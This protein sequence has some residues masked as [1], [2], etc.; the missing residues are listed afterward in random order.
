MLPKDDKLGVL[1]EGPSA[2]VDIKLSK[3]IIFFDMGLGLGER[4]LWALA[5]LSLGFS[6]LVRIVWPPMIYRVFHHNS[7]GE[8]IHYTAH[9]TNMVRIDNVQVMVGN[10]I[11]ST[12]NH[13]FKNANC[14]KKSICAK[15]HLEWQ[16]FLKVK[17][18]GI[19][20]SLSKC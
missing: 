11:M 20:N 4:G 6:A 19:C 3:Y 12:L 18:M 1:W 13:A 5:I 7:Y 8:I 15:H 16:S 17:E 10:K 9:M 14:S 2:L